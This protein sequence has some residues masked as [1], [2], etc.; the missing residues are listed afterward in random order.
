MPL[1]D[2]TAVAQVHQDRQQV[3]SQTRRSTRR[4]EIMFDQ[5]RRDKR[6][7]AENSGRLA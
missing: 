5:V 1:L 4:C 2:F 6:Y 7:N 3:I